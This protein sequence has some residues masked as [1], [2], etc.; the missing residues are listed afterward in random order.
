MCNTQMSL[1]SN[2]HDCGVFAILVM[3]NLRAGAV[4]N[5]GGL[6]EWMR[7]P[8]NTQDMSSVRNILWKKVHS[9]IV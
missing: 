7:I 8:E 6:E 3:F 1:Q 5:D 2:N 4:L 9:A